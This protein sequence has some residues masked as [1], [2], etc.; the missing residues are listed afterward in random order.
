[1]KNG[2]PVSSSSV[3]TQS[4]PAKDDIGNVFAVS[5]TRADN[6]HPELYFGAERL[7]NNGDSHVDFEFLQSIVGLSARCNGVFSGHRTEGDLLAAV[8]FSGG[9]AIANSV[10][11]QWHCA[12][13]P[14]PQPPDGTVCDP[15]G[16]QHYQ[17]LAGSTAIVFTVNSV[18]IACGGWVCRDKITNNTTLIAPNDLME[19]GI[20]LLGLTFTGC[21]NTFLP[22]TR[23]AQSFTAGLKD[24][25][26]PIPLTSCRDPALSSTSSPS[27]AGASPGTAPRDTVSVGNG[28]AGPAPT[29]SV[30]FFLCSPAEVTAAGCPAGG[31]QVGAAKPVVAGSATSDAAPAVTE[32]G[33]YCWRAAYA[34]D[35]AS[36]GV[37]T[38]ATHTDASTECFIVSTPGFPSTGF[39]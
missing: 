18:A 13:E 3:T 19:G 8:D 14:G 15:T 33:T 2:D 12:A 37:Y 36:L 25:T 4:V 10:L 39:P 6:G 35:V 26:G 1:S 24:F 28:G 5:H 38:A 29:G 31:A 17:P 11:Y 7:V 16:I 32:P 23:T 21:F 9:G 30:T 34:P 20:D 27:G 22:H